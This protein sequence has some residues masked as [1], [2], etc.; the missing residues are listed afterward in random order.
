VD[1]TTRIS[2]SE[3]FDHPWFKE[4]IHDRDQMVPTFE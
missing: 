1:P 4:E 2:S 3:L